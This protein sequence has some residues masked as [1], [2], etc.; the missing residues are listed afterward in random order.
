[1]TIKLTILHWLFRLILAGIF[2]YSGYI[3]FPP[4]PLQFPPEYLLQFAQAIE[5]YQIVPESLI[6]PVATWL[7]FLEII[8]GLGLLLGWK[9]RYF[10]AGATA[11]LIFFILLLTVTYFRGIEVSCGCWNLDEP[12]PISLL[13]ILRDG[14]FI[15]PAIYLMLEDRIR[16][17][18]KG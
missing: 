8:L 12:T 9:I 10:A 4:L 15:V 13:T 5:D 3:K 17:R 1:M 6:I 7:P 11:L 14:T 2:L 18:F 16:S